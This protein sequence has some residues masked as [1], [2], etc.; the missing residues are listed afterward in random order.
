ME[1]DMLNEE[2]LLIWKKK[3]GFFIFRTVYKKY[4]L[5]ID[6]GSK[7]SKIK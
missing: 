3:T 5:P 2:I 4:M 6:C 1:K 7:K